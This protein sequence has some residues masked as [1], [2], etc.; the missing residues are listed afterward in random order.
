MDILIYRCTTKLR[1]FKGYCK[2]NTKMLIGCTLSRF[3]FFRSVVL[4]K[5]SRL[6]SG[7]LYSAVSTNALLT[8]DCCRCRALRDITFL[9]YHTIPYLAGASLSAYLATR[10]ANPQ[11]S[12]EGL[13]P[14]RGCTAWQA[15]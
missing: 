5:K 12:A 7:N 8:L 11:T 14:L 9:S 3:T 10:E 6:D 1:F 4:T 15:R 2:V 13:H